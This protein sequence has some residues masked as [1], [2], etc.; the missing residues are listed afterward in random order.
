MDIAFRLETFAA[1]PSTQDLVREKL[2]GV[3]PRLA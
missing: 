3:T 2:E 1:L